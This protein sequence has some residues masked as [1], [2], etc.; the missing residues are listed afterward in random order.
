M[1]EELGLEAQQRAAAAAAREAA[2]ERRKEADKRRRDSEAR[3]APTVR[4]ALPFGSSYCFR[5]TL[6]LSPPPPPPRLQMK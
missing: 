1:W 2:A 3:K 6:V 4:E 5:D